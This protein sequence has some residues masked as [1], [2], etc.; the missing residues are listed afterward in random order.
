MG[1]S[2][3]LSAVIQV[4]CYSQGFASW[5]TVYVRTVEEQEKQEGGEAC[6][7][8]GEKRPTEQT[9]GTDTSCL[10]STWPRSALAYLADQFWDPQSS[11]NLLQAIEVPQGHIQLV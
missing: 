8:G 1:S 3:C 5:A 11:I 7:R 6:L 9:A 2:F 10:W 4:L